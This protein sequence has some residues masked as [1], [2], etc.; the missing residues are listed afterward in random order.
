M[1]K[2]DPSGAFISKWGGHGTAEGRFSFPYDIAVDAAHGGVYVI[3]ND[4]DRVQKF[5]T[6]GKFVSAWGWGVD[7]GSAAYQVCTQGCQAGT[8]GTG[9]GQFKGPRGIATDGTYVYVADWGNKRVQKFDLAGNI[10]GQWTIGAQEAPER[11]AA[12]GGK[13]YATTSKN[14]VWRF[15]S[16]GTPDN[17]W[18]GD[19][20]K[21]SSGT[22]AGQ[23]DFPEGL[24]VDGT[25]VYVTDSGNQ[26]IQKLSSGGAFVTMWGWGVAD[27]SSALQSCSAN[28]QT[29]I[30]GSGDGQFNDPYAVAATGGNVW[31]ADS[32]N[33]RV[34][35]FGQAGLTSSP[36]GRSAPASTTPRRTWRLRRRASCTWQ[37]R[38]GMTS[39]GSTRRGIH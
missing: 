9:S 6:S 15:D 39:S 19:G 1:Q 16:S 28:C 17:T 11:I 26:R 3:D 12:A 2:L 14:V 31:V 10:A 21:G 36:W 24:A 38:R 8:A 7:D 4:N 22:G 30:A 5:D 29:G 35:R 20:V 37:T 32:Y 13:V 27:G 23:F 25:G 34:Q 18:D 33:H